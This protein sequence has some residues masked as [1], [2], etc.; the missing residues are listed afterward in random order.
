MN[1]MRKAIIASAV[2][3][4]ELAEGS[5]KQSFSFD[6]SFLG[7]AGHFP[8]YPILPGVLQNLLAQVVS[9]QVISDPV[10]FRA[11]QRAKFSRQLR[12][13]DQIEVE[14][15]CRDKEGALYCATKM[16][17]GSEEA[18]SFTL[19]LEKKATT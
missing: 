7:F 15:I 19:I 6:E 17:V 3:P 1:R 11:I 4:V 16:R 5:G 2:G 14:V 18:S 10:E 8:G 13:G 12:P 9:E